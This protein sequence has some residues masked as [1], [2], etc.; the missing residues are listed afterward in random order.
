M[1]GFGGG[2]ELGGGIRGDDV[3]AKYVSQVDSRMSIAQDIKITN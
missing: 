3:S 1:F 2:D